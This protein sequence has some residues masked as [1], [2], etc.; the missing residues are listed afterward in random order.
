MAIRQSL[1]SIM[2]LAL[3]ASPGLSATAPGFDLRKELA[4]LKEADKVPFDD[5][6]PALGYDYAMLRVPFVRG[7]GIP[8]YGSGMSAERNKF[9]P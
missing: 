4:E 2:V 9:S 8:S 3:T 6:N 5:F 7:V 1:V